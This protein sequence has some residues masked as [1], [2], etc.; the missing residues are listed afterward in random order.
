MG[1]DALPLE[2]RDILGKI[3]QVKLLKRL[4]TQREDFGLYYGQFPVIETV[5]RH[6]GC[7]Q[8]EL[9]DMLMVSPASIAVSTK[10]LEKSGLLI[11]KTD[12]NNARCNRISITEQG[13]Q[14][15]DCCRGIFDK[16]DS[17]AFEGF[18]DEELDEF[19]AYLDRIIVNLGGD[20]A[21]NGPC[22]IA[23]LAGEVADNERKMAKQQEEDADND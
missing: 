22:V 11:R 16:V 23:A 2:K 7:T 19:T 6:D 13:I 21:R 3:T 15:S 12:E 4:A 9:A 17:L 1:G 18:S 5:R 14:V 10:R 8:K 20:A